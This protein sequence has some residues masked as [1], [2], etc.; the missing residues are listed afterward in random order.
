MNH[1]PLFVDFQNITVAHN[2]TILLH[3][4]S[5]QI[6]DGEHVAIL[7]PNGSGKSTFIRT[8]IR[9]HYPVYSESGSVFRIWGQE[10][11]GRLYSSIPFRVCIPGPPIYISPEYFRERG[12]SIR[13]FSSIGLFFHTITPEMEK[14]GR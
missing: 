12:D 14:Q 7:G 3:A 5:V 10:T 11:W 13:L 9:E 2:T 8:L 6:P 1:T 4:L